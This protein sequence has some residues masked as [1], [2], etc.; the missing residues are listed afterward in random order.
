MTQF[1]LKVR[2]GFGWLVL[3]AFVCGFFWSPVGA[4]T[5][6]ILGVWFVG[7]QRIRAGFLWILAIGFVPAAVRHWRM[8][9]AH[10]GLG[11]VLLLAAAVIGVLPFLVHRLAN[12]RLN[13][14][15]WTLPF[16]LASLALAWAVPHW[17][18]P[19]SA[20][21]FRSSLAVFEPVEALNAAGALRVFGVAWFAAMVVCLWDREFRLSGLLRPFA[22]RPRPWDQRM[23]TIALL[24]SPESGS[25]VQL[26]GEGSNLHL[27]STAGEVFPMRNGMP[28][29]LRPRDLTGMNRKY[30]KLY[31]TIGGFYDDSQRVIMALGGLDRD[32]YVMGYL[33]LLGVKPGDAVL[34]TS[35][36][37]GLNFKYLPRQIR[38]FGLDLSREMLL[39]CQANL[40]RWD[41]Q[42][43]L[44]VGNAEALPFADE[45][46][47]VVFHVGGINFFS[48]R[49][50][51]IREMIRVARPGSLLLIADETEEHVKAAY[52]NIP[53]AREFY[54]GRED[55]VSV[56]VDL[57]PAE[58]EEVHAK[59]L[60]I[61]GKK[62]FY[63]LTFRKPRV[64]ARELAVVS[65]AEAAR[66]TMKA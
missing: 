58:M 47:D 49:A 53:Y 23:D 62:R 33:D 66:P 22:A 11:A 63:A 50:A 35:V 7:T 21:A 38:R 20:G 31:E 42:A 65:G 19:L 41:M 61:A 37:T 6:P 43:D 46:F 30:N 39:R 8:L 29:F 57:V 45:S 16:P 32:V 64:A 26:A 44:F 51:A 52:E 9:G 56:P 12:T 3:A 5:G 1:E 36:G 13:G 24:R 28:V 59:I 14:I 54:K 2:Q 18:A 60:E 55:A 48:D 15:A 4:W 17:L 34:E 27:E 25:P 40:R 10:D